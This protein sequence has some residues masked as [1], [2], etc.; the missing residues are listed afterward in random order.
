MPGLPLMICR[1]QSANRE[2]GVGPAKPRR[3][4]NDL[5]AAQH[6]IAGPAIRRERHGPEVSMTRLGRVSDG[7]E[8]GSARHANEWLL[9][10]SEDRGAK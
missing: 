9:R 2:N 10:K 3:C 8:L 6:Q 1:H 5:P 4:P 7:P